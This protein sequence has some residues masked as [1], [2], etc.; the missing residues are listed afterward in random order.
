MEHLGTLVAFVHAAETRSFVAAGRK[1]GLSAS[2]VGKAITRLE[3]RLGVRLFHRSTRSMG[4]TEEG[5]MFLI[6]CRRILDE[7]E[8]AE[9]EMTQVAKAPNGRLRVS[10]PMIA[11][12]L[13]PVLSDFMETFPAITLDL[14]FSDRLVDVIEEGYDVVIRTGP[15]M[16]STLMRRSLGRF[17]GRIVAAPSY[18][19]QHGRPEVPEDVADHKC[20]RQRSHVTGKLIEW[21]FIPQET[22]EPLIIPEALSANSIGP[23]IDF[24][25]MGRGLA[26]LPSFAVFSQIEQGTL[27]PLL[28]DYLQETGEFSA[29]WPTSRQLSPRIRAFVS[30]LADHMDPDLGKIDAQAVRN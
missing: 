1:T 16:D 3:T 24:A 5:R 11:M 29:L 8:A 20:L 25:Q 22:T 4:L 13:A 19:A 10:M 23:L 14:D 6:R 28:D 21:P 2:A 17:R 9:L 7:I 26:F 15:A 12:L 18:L 27:V 30:H